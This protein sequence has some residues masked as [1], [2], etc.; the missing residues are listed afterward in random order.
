MADSDEE[1]S[2]R[3]RNERQTKDYGAPSAKRKREDSELQAR[4]SRPKV[5]DLNA[6]VISTFKV[7][8]YFFLHNFGIFGTFLAFHTKKLIVCK[9]HSFYHIVLWCQKYSQKFFKFLSKI[10]FIAM[11]PRPRRINHA[12][13]GLWKLQVL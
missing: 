11:D 13:I 1:R 2:G 7:S 6:P 10:S 3:F 12:G 8:I 5:V 4:P 9:S